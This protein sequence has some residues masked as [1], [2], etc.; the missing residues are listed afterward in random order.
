MNG[1]VIDV[2]GKWSN[3][4]C[5]SFWNFRYWYAFAEAGAE[6]S[7]ALSATSGVEAITATTC[8]YYG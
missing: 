8:G 1:C 6:T 2:T 7:D 5:D 4:I 3:R